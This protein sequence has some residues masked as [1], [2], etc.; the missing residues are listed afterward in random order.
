MGMNKSLVQRLHLISWER[1]RIFPDQSQKKAKQNQCNHNYFRKLLYLV[2]QCVS[3]CGVIRIGR[4]VSNY[5]NIA[6]NFVF[7]HDIMMIV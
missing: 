3:S 7:H 1:G 5:L 6:L 4:E 2:F